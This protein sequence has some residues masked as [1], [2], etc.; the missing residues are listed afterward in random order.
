[1]NTMAHSANYLADPSQDY[2]KWAQAYRMLGG[3]IDCDHDKEASHSNDKNNGQACSR[4][5]LW[6][7]V[8]MTKVIRLLSN[9]TALTD[10]LNS[11]LRIVR[12]SKLPRRRVR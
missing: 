3:Y 2:D 8:S 9:S 6:A 11:V 10:S 5:M 12:E 1:V 4:W 7:A